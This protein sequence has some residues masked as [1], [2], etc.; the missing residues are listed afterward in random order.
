VRFTAANTV[1]AVNDPASVPALVALLETEE[2]LRVKNRIA[3]GLAERGWSIAPELQDVCR[4]ALP[5]GYSLSAD[6]V[7]RAG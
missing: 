4:A 7:V 1:F 3:Q 5:P 6:K 2:S